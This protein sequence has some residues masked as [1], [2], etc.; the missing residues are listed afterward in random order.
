MDAD[1]VIGYA[2]EA[3]RANADFR[4]HPLA[5]WVFTRSATHM[6][7]W[8]INGSAPAALP[9]PA[10]H[11]PRRRGPAPAAPSLSFDERRRFFDHLRR[12]AELA[13]GAGEEGALLRRQA[14][15]LCSYDSAPDTH[16][17]LGAMQSRRATRLTHSAWA[18]AWSDARSLATSL[19]RHGDVEMLHAFIERGMSSDAGETANLNYWA[20]WLGLDRL[21]RSDDSFMAD[22]APRSWD[23][24]ALLR[25]LADRLDP[26]LGC[27]DLNVHSVWAL[28]ASHPGLL[29]TDHQGDLRRRV[30]VL[31]DTDRVSRRARRELD[32]LHYGLRLSRP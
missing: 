27:V 29:A 20:H 16:A 31:L 30:A 5:G 12:S 22:P 17:W 26:A 25:R 23:P 10:R 28:V 6:L 8:A 24:G 13:D 11:V 21:P 19:T 3:G 7:T 1:S 14:L 4:D 32:S 2:L 15:Y 18:P 9:Q